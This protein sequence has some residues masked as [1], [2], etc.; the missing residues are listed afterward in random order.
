MLT[1]HPC[2]QRL[3]DPIR[4]VCLRIRMAPRTDSRT[5]ALAARANFL[6][7]S[8]QLEERPGLVFSGGASLV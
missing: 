6:K 5:M 3:L 4:L 1:I 7:E 8:G 2:V